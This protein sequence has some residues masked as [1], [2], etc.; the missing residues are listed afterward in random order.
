MSS[1]YFLG[2]NTSYIS[3]PNDISLNFETHDFTVE[4]FQYQTDSNPNP[5]IFQK[6]T[7]GSDILFGVSI[8]GGR[9]YY[10]R[11]NTAYLV[12]TLSSSAYK[13]KWVHFAVC[14][15]SGIT[16][17][18]MN[19]TSIYTLA[20]TYNYLNTA[21]LIVSNESTLITTSA[22]GGYMY[23]FHFI[24]G[25]AK[26][27]SDF[28]AT[29]GL[30]TVLPETVLLLKASGASGTLANT[31]TSTAGTFA[32]VPTLSSPPPSVAPPSTS[33]KPIFTDNSRVYYKSNSLASGGVGGVRN[34]RRKSRRT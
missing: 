22:F 12:T 25:I 8:E 21:N 20:D 17:I 6:G 11:N 28:T 31:I 19:G 2:N 26:Y 30:P 32:I 15:S 29:T 16:K 23:Y 10:W 24:K 18:Y 4:W 3:I 27:T 13:N 33:M 9:F 7:Y 34:H 5:R 14:R 1:L